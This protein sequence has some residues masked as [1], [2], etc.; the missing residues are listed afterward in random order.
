M[1]YLVIGNDFDMQ[2]ALQKTVE[3]VTTPYDLTNATKLRLA[4]IGRG[5]YVFAYDV[6][7]SPLSSNTLIGTM[8]GRELLKG[9][10]GLE[11]TF[12]D[13]GK[14]K[15]FFVDDMFTAVNEIVEDSD[16]EAEGE[17]G[18]IEV[19]IT[20][21]PE[22]IDFSGQMGTAAGFGTPTIEVDANVG[23]PSA[24]ISAEGPDTAKIFHFLFHNIKGEPGQDGRDG[25]D[26]SDA[27]V[28]AE[29]IAAALGYTPVS[30]TELAA[31]TDLFWATYGTTTYA[32]IKTAIDAG[33][34]VLC[35][36]GGLT[37][38][39]IRHEPSPLEVVW[40]AAI[41]YEESVA[42]V[43]ALENDK[44]LGWS[45]SDS[46]LA[47]QANLNTKQDTINDLSTIRIGAAAGAT[48]YQKPGTGIPSSDMA[49]A[50]QTSLGKA[51]SAYQKP[52]TGIPSTDLADA[53]QTSLGKADTAY[54]KPSG[55]ITTSDLASGVTTSLGK[56]DTAY[57]KPSGGIPASDLASAVQT[58]L[59]KADTAVQDV[60]GKEDKSNKVTSISGSSTDT[61][62]PSA[63]LLYDQLATKQATLVSGTNIKTI[64][65]NSILGE[66]NITIEGGGTIDIDEN[67][68]SGSENA[69]SSGGVYTAL[70]GKQAT[71]T[72]DNTPTAS[73]NNPV[74]SGGVYTALAGKQ[75]TLTFDNTPT[76]SSNNPV[77]S[78]GVYTALAA[79]YEKPSGG[80][81]STDLAS[82]V[83]TLLGKTIASVTSAQDGSVVITLS[84]GDTYT[85]DLNH[86]HPQYYSKAVETTQPSGG[87]LPDV[88]YNLGEISGTVTFALASAVSG[89]LNHYYWAFDT[90]STAPTV[91]WPSSGFT[92][93]DGTGPTVAASKHYEI[94]VLNGIATFLEV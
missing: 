14:D 57:Q 53:V 78:G 24:E 18:G 1:I 42:H 32:Q 26:G 50:V 9:S 52:G 61:Q 69:V 48:A 43:Y 30:P 87:F 55:G 75:D 63:K 16:D 86:N 39:L 21:E 76:S 31:R 71:L 40:F 79:K 45:N 6:E 33:K 11:V 4:L 77:K 94:S 72:F 84:S 70:Q 73:S 54:Q 44:R 7:V 5:K 38:R 64:N 59:G 22:V 41:E 49:S 60:S 3:D 80:I 36:R 65:N 15:R 35:N 66:G 58:S 67:P 91:T 90:G 23:T 2:V 12:N 82:A 28:T 92:W 27:D 34:E 29:N 25:R 85:I 17:G 93:A 88:N 47:T 8:P 74:K 81:P 10:Y 56:A 19:T 13:G 89:N 68:T 62:Y 37:Y 20:V 83:Q 46:R 51:D